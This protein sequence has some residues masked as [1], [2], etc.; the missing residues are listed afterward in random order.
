MSQ[1]PDDPSTS[2][3]NPNFETIFA[4]A[5]EKYKKRTKKDI[6][7]HSLAA[8]IQSCKSPK[9]VLT[10]LQT[11]VQ[12]FDPSPSANERWT[13]MLDPTITVLFALSGFV[14]NIA[15]QVF[16]PSTAIFTGI[17]ALLQAVKDVRATQDTLVSMFDRMRNFFMRLEKYIAI[18]PTPA[19]TEV[20]VQ[21]MVEVISILGIATKEIKEWKIKKF[22][23]RLVGLNRLND[24]LQ[25]LENVRAEEALMAGA[26]T[27]EIAARIDQNVHHMGVNVAGMTGQLQSG[28]ADI[29]HEVRSMHA[30]V[31]EARD[32]MHVVLKYVSDRDRNESRKELRQWIAAPDPSSNLYT[33]S[34]VHHEGTAA[35][36]TEGKT[37]ADWM[38]SGS[39]LW[40]HGKPGSGKTILS[41]VIVRHI[42]KLPNVKSVLLAYFY[43]DF[44]DEGK[45]DSRAL[46]SSLLNQLSNQSDQFRDVLRGLYSE[47]EDGSKQPHNDALLR[48]L[49]VML[50]IGRSVPIYLVVDALDEC[51]NDSGELPSRSRRGKVLSL[52][53]ELVKLRLP[54]LRF[55]ITSRPEVDIRTI[56][57]P[58][59]TQ[60][61]S[62][63]DES[64]QNRD[65][66]VYI[67]AIVQS[68]KKWR[69]DDKK[70]VIDKL[71]ENADGM[72][73][74]VYC[75]LEALQP[76]FPNNLRR[77]LEELPKSLDETYQRILKEI[78]NANQK[79]AH[80]LL[81][82]LTVARR[83]L[84]V[85]E[86]AE[87]L[88]LDAGAGGIPTFNPNWRWEDH[89][90]AVLS[91]CSS[92]VSVIIDD[93]SHVVQFSHFS[94][95]EFLTSDR[96]ASMEDVSQF[97]IADEP[98]HLILA[99]ACLGVLLNMDNR[100]S[101]DS[102]EDIALLP[103]AD[104]YWEEHAQVAN[105]E[106]RI[107]DALDCLFDLDKPHLEV[108]LRRKGTDRELRS[109]RAPS[110][111]SPEGVL[112][113][114]TPFFFAVHLKPGGKIQ[115]LCDSC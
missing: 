41:S 66:N 110:D 34:D 53:E 94:V 16:P 11:Q 92:L 63:H 60:E 22:S 59:A 111:E 10:I 19:M 12:T 109:F 21:V 113:P 46:L 38:E 24:A 58:L 42:E 87:V 68:V 23:K 98:S 7:A 61:I 20:I 17:G 51:P 64:G 90:A 86:L 27:L 29:Q 70:M 65:I 69:D 48:C 108:L 74:W 97:L 9:A 37:F 56:V 82:C 35:W 67:T 13:S 14:G 40:I 5:L 52:V 102:V 2:T 106:L 50:T 57:K 36:C 54:N 3:S 1:N 91:A 33:A 47:H 44:K 26:E 88:A 39:L 75:Q 62:L 115:I 96:L 100:T 45:K 105:V 4:D 77:M 99:Q 112:N 103:Y 6:A 101:E 78:N 25:Q 81:Q 79:Q 18:R 83:P 72:F 84:R 55:C 114:V 93:G 76:C 49:K 104:E 80:Q 95:K 31:T 85:E 8:D 28:Q 71:T 15:G 30:G 43:F 89:E 32:E 107:K 73:R